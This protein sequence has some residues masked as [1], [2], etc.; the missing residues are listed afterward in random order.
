MCMCAVCVFVRRVCLYVYVQCVSMCVGACV[1][2]CVRA[3]CAYVCGCVCVRVCMSVNPRPVRSPPA[4]FFRPHLRGGR[5]RRRGAQ[6]PRIPPRHLRQ[7]VSHASAVRSD[8]SA[9]CLLL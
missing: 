8:T 5:L 1:Y 6:P 4:L 2:M 3:V 9:S 7:E